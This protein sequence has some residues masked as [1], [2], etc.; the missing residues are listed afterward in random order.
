MEVILISHK[1]GLSYRQDSTHYSADC[2]QNEKNTQGLAIGF[3]P[4]L[5]IMKQIFTIGYTSTL[6]AILFYNLHSP[7]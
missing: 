6:S 5:N 2:V 7:N 1:C 3:D 4:K